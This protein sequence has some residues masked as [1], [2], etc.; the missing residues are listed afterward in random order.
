MSFEKSYS[1]YECIT[2]IS[3]DG[4]LKLTGKKREQTQKNTL[5]NPKIELKDQHCLSLSNLFS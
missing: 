1:E 3:E 4:K 5:R 2:V